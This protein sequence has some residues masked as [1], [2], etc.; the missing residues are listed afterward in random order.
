MY[1]TY[2]QINLQHSRDAMACLAKQMSKM[3]GPV[4]VA[5]QEPYFSRSGK[6]M[7]LPRDVSVHSM[8]GK[9]R[10]ALFTRGIHLWADHGRTN[11]DVESA[12]IATDVGVLRIASVCLVS[13][14]LRFRGR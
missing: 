5:A 7:G 9:P 11:R 12:V 13:I 8:V 10:A 2:W 6:V 4:I 3:D 14:C 1:V